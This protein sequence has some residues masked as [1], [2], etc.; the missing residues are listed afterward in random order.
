MGD[1]YLLPYQD[2]LTVLQEWMKSD[3]QHANRFL[4][5]YMRITNVIPSDQEFM[6]AI[7]FITTGQFISSGDETIKLQKLLVEQLEKCKPSRKIYLLRVQDV[8]LPGSCPVPPSNQPQHKRRRIRVNTQENKMISNIKDEWRD[9]D[10]TMA[11]ILLCERMQ[12]MSR[13]FPSLIVKECLDQSMVLPDHV[14]DELQQRLS[15]RD[16]TLSHCKQQCLEA[17]HGQYP[18]WRSILNLMVQYTDLWIDEWIQP[19]VMDIFVKIIRDNHMI[20]DCYHNLYKAL[21]RIPAQKQD[22]RKM[23]Q[24]CRFFR[25]LL[26][27]VESKNEL[28][29]I[30]NYIFEHMTRYHGVE[31]NLFN[32]FQ[33]LDFNGELTRLLNQCSNK[34]VN[35]D[36]AA[37]G[38]TVNLISQ[39]ELEYLRTNVSAIASLFKMCCSSTVG[40]ES[41]FGEYPAI[42][43]PRD[44]VRTD[45]D[46]LFDPTDFIVNELPLLLSAQDEQWIM[47]ELGLRILYA[48]YGSDKVQRNK[49]SDANV[50]K[51]AVLSN[52]APVDLC[53]ALTEVL[54]IRY[55]QRKSSTPSIQLLETSFDLLKTTLHALIQNANITFFEEDVNGIFTQLEMNYEKLFSAK[56]VWKCHLK[57]LF[58]H[59]M[60]DTIVTHHL[61][62]SLYP[63]LSLSVSA[64]YEQLLVNFLDHLYDSFD[65]HH[66]II[67]FAYSNDALNPFAKMLTKRDA[68]ILYKVLYCTK[69][70]GQKDPP[71]ASRVY[72]TYFVTCIVRILQGMHNWA[73]PFP[74]YAQNPSLNS[75][76]DDMYTDPFVSKNVAGVYDG[77][78]KSIEG[79]DIDNPQAS[80][81]QI[82]VIDIF[83]PLYN[84]EMASRK[85]LSLLT[86][87]LVCESI[88]HMGDDNELSESIRVF[89][90]QIIEGLRDTRQR[91][92]F[93]E[94]AATQ[95]KSRLV[96]WRKTSGQKRRAI[97]RPLLSDQEE[98]LM[99]P[100]FSKLG[101]DRSKALLGL[102]EEE[103]QESSRGKLAK[104]HTAIYCVPPQ[105]P[106]ST[107]V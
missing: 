99:I 46:V 68:K 48:L 31:Y 42:L 103:Q 83:Y 98:R 69:L 39:S 70:L 23:E 13:P 75:V 21:Y 33:E 16:D 47:K 63:G 56:H 15:Q 80:T 64:E 52:A 27:S 93:R 30:R 38:L 106:K 97:L 40:K 51:L 88:L 2:A 90:L 77:E 86:M 6:D 17:L 32:G 36:H 76:R 74:Q 85:A 57:T 34:H 18:S 60:E 94:L 91:R 41:S 82:V 89:M 95:Q 87:C 107:L 29:T 10:H 22:E 19:N 67:D 66:M 11:F 7:A 92:M 104:K 50:V 35:W 14:F 43:I 84:D 53:L 37:K 1:V 12:E 72:Q 49:F 71:E 45:Q 58:Q 59:P 25:Q 102:L 73:D 9:N 3:D 8:C 96:K 20:I 78:D 4:V 5:H 62:Q 55:S 65:A 26:E 105:K 54:E 100:Y 81:Q 101:P 28:M 44:H 24:Q 61:Y 79:Y